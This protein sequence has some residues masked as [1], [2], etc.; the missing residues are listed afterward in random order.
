MKEFL[1]DRV[2]SILLYLQTAYT[3]WVFLRSAKFLR[4]PYIFLSSFWHSFSLFLP[5]RRLVAHL[6]HDGEVI[7]PYY[8]PL[9]EEREL[10]L[11]QVGKRLHFSMTNSKNN[12]VR[13]MCDI[14]EK[15]YILSLNKMYFDFIFTQSRDVLFPNLTI[16]KLLSREDMFCLF[17]EGYRPNIY[18]E[19]CI[20]DQSSS[21]EL[22]RD[23]MKL[24]SILPVYLQAKNANSLSAIV[25]VFIIIFDFF[26]YYPN[27]LWQYTKRLIYKNTKILISHGGL[28]FRDFAHTFLSTISEEFMYCDR[29]RKKCYNSKVDSLFLIE[30]CTL[31]DYIG[32]VIEFEL[33]GQVTCKNGDWHEKIFIIG[34]DEHRF[35]YKYSNPIKATYQYDYDLNGRFLLVQY[36]CDEDVFENDLRFMSH[37]EDTQM[38]PALYVSDAGIHIQRSDKLLEELYEF[39]SV[40]Y[41]LLKKA[42]VS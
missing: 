37:L 6:V 7:R 34:L 2:I 31:P 18:V 20:V 30:P 5:K 26:L 35:K 33:N 1:N 27:K 22:N 16:V 10:I 28:N 3:I 29:S 4:L 32:E 25:F 40:K 23:F 41:K 42:F 36:N 38:Y 11:E 15:D 24:I 17:L 19:R 14:E 8:G 21:F 12:R 13:F 9:S 39:R